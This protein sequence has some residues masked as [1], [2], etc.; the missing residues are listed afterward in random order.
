MLIHYEFDP[1]T[2]DLLLEGLHHLP[3]GRVR[4]TFDSI[5]DHAEKTI[6]AHAKEQEGQQQDHPPATK[7]PR[8]LTRKAR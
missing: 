6:A 3:H 5:R 7:P 4:G 1:A 8:R 2:V